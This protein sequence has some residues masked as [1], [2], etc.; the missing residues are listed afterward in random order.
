MKVQPHLENPSLKCS[1]KGKTPGVSVPGRNFV[2]E[3][4]PSSE[5]E[6]HEACCSL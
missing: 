3:L 4:T 5:S 6:L 2:R 1:A